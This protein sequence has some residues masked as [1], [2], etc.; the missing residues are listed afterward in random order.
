MVKGKHDGQIGDQKV[1]ANQVSGCE[2]VSHAH[3]PSGP[4]SRKL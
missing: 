4:I 2:Q 3:L 1:L